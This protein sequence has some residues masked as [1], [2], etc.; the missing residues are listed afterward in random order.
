MSVTNAWSAA[1]RGGLDEA[2]ECGHSRSI[3][4]LYYKI[5]MNIVTS[6]IRKAHERL[7]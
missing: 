6:D 1:V 7:V 4:K 3:W 5:T 2:I